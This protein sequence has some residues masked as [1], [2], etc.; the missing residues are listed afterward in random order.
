MFRGV[1]F[2]N[3]FHGLEV[4]RTLFDKSLVVQ[5]F[6]DD[7]VHHAVDPGHVS[8]QVR[9]QPILGKLRHLDSSG[10]HHDEFGP[11]AGHGPFDKGSRARGGFP[12]YWS[13]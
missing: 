7:D 11:A 4:F 1:F 12:W 5:I 9:P 2:H 13:R 3:G 10:V 8:S 6:T